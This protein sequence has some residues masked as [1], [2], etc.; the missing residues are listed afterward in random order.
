MHVCNTYLTV[1]SCFN[2][3][4]VGDHVVGFQ[5]LIYRSCNTMYMRIENLLKTCD[6]N[7]SK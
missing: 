4:F 7:I 6:P 1:P 5:K 2:T 3:E